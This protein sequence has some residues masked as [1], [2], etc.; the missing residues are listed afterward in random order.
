M[1]LSNLKSITYII[2]WISRK[3]GRK[4]SVLV[5]WI[6]YFMCDFPGSLCSTSHLA[7]G[8]HC[9]V[10]T[11]EDISDY[12]L[13]LRLEFC[14]SQKVIRYS[15]HEN[16]V[17]DEGGQWKS[18]TGSVESH[19]SSKESFYCL[20]THNLFAISWWKYRFCNSKLQSYWSL[21]E[22]LQS[23]T[24]VRTKDKYVHSASIPSNT[25]VHPNHW[26]VPAAAFWLSIQ[27]IFTN[28]GWNQQIYTP[29]V[30]S[31]VTV[32]QETIVTTE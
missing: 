26:H 24:N 7:W 10:N 21:W 5:V 9:I 17:G 32:I 27:K 14:T 2:I 28:K 6:T 18:V 29:W 8:G 22:E 30:P 31:F 3:V 11:E 16:W 1:L 23:Y 12:I 19:G 13:S 20:K 25:C 4:V 15:A